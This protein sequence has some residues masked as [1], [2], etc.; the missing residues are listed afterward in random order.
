MLRFVNMFL[1]FPRCFLELSSLFNDVNLVL[2]RSVN[3]N[4]LFNF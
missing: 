3:I 4:V 2:S 1:I